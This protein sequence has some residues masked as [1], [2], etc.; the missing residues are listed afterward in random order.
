M[1]FGEIVSLS[2]WC[3]P[4]VFDLGMALPCHASTGRGGGGGGVLS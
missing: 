2:L 4:V 3:D 1:S